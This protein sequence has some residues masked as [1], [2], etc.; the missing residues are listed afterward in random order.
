M[1]GVCKHRRGLRHAAVRP[2]PLYIVN[3]KIVKYVSLLAKLVIFFV[4]LLS[5]L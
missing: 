1:D 3:V 5:V 4:S 2:A